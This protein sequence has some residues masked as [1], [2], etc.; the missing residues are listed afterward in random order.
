MDSLQ[1]NEKSVDL[2]AVMSNKDQ[3]VYSNCEVCLTLW[4]W[5]VDPN[6]EAGEKCQWENYWKTTMKTTMKTTGWP[7]INVFTLVK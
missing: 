6:H 3:T 1:Q 5:N 2:K 4:K 7:V